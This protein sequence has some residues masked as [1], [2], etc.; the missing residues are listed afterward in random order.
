M[1]IFIIAFDIANKKKFGIL[2]FFIFIWVGLAL[3]VFTIFPNALNR[4][5]SLFW[6]ARWAD[7]LVYASI[8]F[9]LYFV[10]LLFKK[11]VE[12]QEDLTS[13][14]RE[15][16]IE[17]SKKE[18]IKWK[19]VFVIPVYN[20]KDVV[21]DTIKSILK[22]WYENILIVNDGSKDGSK[23]VLEDFGDKIVLLNHMKNRGQG[24]ALETGFEYLRRYWDTDFVIT[25][26]S[27]WQ[28]DIDDLPK[29]FEEAKK[30]EKTDI[31]L[32]SRFLKKNNDVPFTRK[33]VLKMWI[34]FT[35]IVSSIKLSDAHNGYR[36]IR[37]PL[38]DKMKITQDWMSH[39]SEIVD[40]IS[41]EKI[42]YKEV[43]VTIKYTDYS[44]GKGQKSSNAINIALR[45]IWNKFFR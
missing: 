1:I 35:Y 45:T 16:A 14:I 33:I 18:K 34:F 43:P 19:E 7:V 10:L 40:I 2:H 17:S 41:V 20:E 9:L 25:F 42:K 44:L 28:H 15:F 38:L 27:D 13:F 5:W 30:H 6:V 22:E 26:D 8:V 11:H 37:T 12:N 39:A 3:T 4:V 24:A 29:F 21:T 23:E 36:L 31:F 32:W